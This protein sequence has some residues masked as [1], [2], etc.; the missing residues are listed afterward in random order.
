M[1]SINTLT[2]CVM[3]LPQ[4][5]SMHFDYE[6]NRYTQERN[7]L[8][9]DIIYNIKK[10]VVCINN[11]QPIAILMGGSPASGKSTFLKKYSPY[12]LNEEITS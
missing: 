8:H 3:S 2:N 5:K 12:L 7:R 1:D 6:T 9:K 4:T 11:D 10:D